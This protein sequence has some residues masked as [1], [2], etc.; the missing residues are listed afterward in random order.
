MSR[1]PTKRQLDS[2]RRK[3]QRDHESALARATPRGGLDAAGRA[4]A[5]RIIARHRRGR[6]RSRPPDELMRVWLLIEVLKNTYPKVDVTVLIALQAEALEGK[7]IG[8]L[9]WIT[10]GA[11]AEREARGIEPVKYRIKNRGTLRRRYNA[12][13]SL[14]KKDADLRA[15]WQSVLG[16]LM[17]KLR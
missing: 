12:A 5:D 16:E 10:G 11:H 8:L 9:N 15:W 4:A 3:V 2:F 1:R 13:Q 14:I 6:K 7:D 17:S